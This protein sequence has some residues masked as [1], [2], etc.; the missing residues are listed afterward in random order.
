MSFENNISVFKKYF[1]RIFFL[2]FRRIFFILLRTS[3]YNMFVSQSYFSTQLL[4]I[5]YKVILIIKLCCVKERTDK[6]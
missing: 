4:S 6:C 1:V 3:N 5:A 2:F